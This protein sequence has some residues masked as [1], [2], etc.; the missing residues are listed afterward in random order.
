MKPDLVGKNK[1]SAKQKLKT[2]SEKKTISVNSSSSSSSKSS[3]SST[4]SPG[5]YYE[6]NI[7]GSANAELEDKFEKLGFR[8]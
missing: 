8:Q 1:A 6:E 2:H 4:S 7:R 5:L 3:N